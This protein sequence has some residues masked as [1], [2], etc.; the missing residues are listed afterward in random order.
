M[1]SSSKSCE[2]DVLAGTGAGFAAAGFV[3]GGGAAAL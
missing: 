3:T 1:A 2:P